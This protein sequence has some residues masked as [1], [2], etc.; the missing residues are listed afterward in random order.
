MG[1]K[2][3]DNSFVMNQLMNDMNT[4]AESTRDS[5]TAIWRKKIL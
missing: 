2:A 4:D 3:H 1:F 5:V